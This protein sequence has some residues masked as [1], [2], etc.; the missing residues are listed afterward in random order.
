M[1]LYNK[2]QNILNSIQYSHYLYVRI[3][4]KT[5]TIWNLDCTKIFKIK[6]YSTGNVCFRQMAPKK[7]PTKII[8]DI[9][10]FLELLQTIPSKNSIAFKKYINTLIKNKLI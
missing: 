1:D 5:I 9:N 6:C 8:K 7:L 3:I 4:D 10:H 2:I